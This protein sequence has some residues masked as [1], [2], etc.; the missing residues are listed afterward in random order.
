MEIPKEEKSEKK[1]QKKKK[2]KR[3]RERESIVL[4]VCLW[5]TTGGGTMLSLSRDPNQCLC[6]HHSPTFHIASARQAAY[7]VPLT[8]R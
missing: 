6:V 7:Y 5:N 4:L 1:K 2:K 8:H 3:E